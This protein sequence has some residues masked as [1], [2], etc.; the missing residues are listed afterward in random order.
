[1]T[2]GDHIRKRRLD[3]GLLQRD[4]AQRIGAD[5][6]SVW[7]WENG[8]SEPALRLLPAV[9]AF[10][11]YAP[12][13]AAE[14]LGDRLVSFRQVRGWSQKQL[15]DA[16]GVDPTTLSRWETGKREPWGEYAT[17]VQGLLLS[18]PAPASTCPCPGIS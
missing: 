1:V 3:L 5:E 12:S 13:K 2:L 8:N 6:S 7:N 9:F 11:G 10:L 15:A 18:A 4:V 17:R 16:L 14:S